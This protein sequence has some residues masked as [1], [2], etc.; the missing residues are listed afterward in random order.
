MNYT[1]LPARVLAKLL[2]LEDTVEHLTQRIAATQDG[3]TSARARL[4]GGFE[5]QVEGDD[6]AASLKQLVADQPELQHKLHAAQVALT[7]CKRWLDQLPEGVALEPVEVKLNGQGAENILA[8]IAAIATEL[9]NLRAVLVPSADIER[10]I[11]AYVRDM[12]R[13]EI[14]GVGSGEHLRVIW[15]GAGFDQAGPREGRADVLPLMALLHGDAMVAALMHEIEH[16]AGTTAQRAER[17]KRI[18]RLD[19]EL[20]TLQREALALG[21]EL[22][23]VPPAVLLGVRVAARQARVA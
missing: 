23:A 11:E 5:K 20:E 13:P 21:A 7:A 16:K 14:T 6:L 3:V 2:A 12:A 22:N 18:A 10:R 9:A 15:P 8:Q 17:T 4:A 1:K 19:F